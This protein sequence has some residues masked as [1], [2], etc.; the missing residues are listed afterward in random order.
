M[1]TIIASLVLPPIVAYVV[2]RWNYAR[3]IASHGERIVRTLPAGTAREIAEQAVIAANFAEV[4]RQ[5]VIAA[6]QLRE[7]EIRIAAI[8]A[9]AGEVNVGSL[10]K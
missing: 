5:M 3:V 2:D 6:A 4:N 1:W 7:H 10:K 8:K 9:G